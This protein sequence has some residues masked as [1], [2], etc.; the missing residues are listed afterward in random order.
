MLFLL[1]LQRSD[2]GYETYTALQYA[3]KYGSRNLESLHH[4]L[5][6][7]RIANSINMQNMDGMTALQL[8]IYYHGDTDPKNPKLPIDNMQAIRCLIQHEAINLD[9]AVSST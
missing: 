9:I 5:S 8:A 1:S 2:G 3:A 7:N 4:L 6:S